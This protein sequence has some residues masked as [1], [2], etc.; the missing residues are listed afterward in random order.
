MG[1]IWLP[2]EK[3]DLLLSVE[4]YECCFCEKFISEKAMD[5][6]WGLF[7]LYYI[8]SCDGIAWE[9]ANLSKEWHFCVWLC[10]LRK[11]LTDHIATTSEVILECE[12]VLYVFNGL[13]H[14]YLT[15][16]TTFNMTQVKPF[17]G[18]LHNQLKNFERMLLAYEGVNQDLL[19]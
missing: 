6:T 13:G 9:D 15:F 14:R 4:W 11:T 8:T 1:A 18:M 3:L 19:F 12:M 5:S 10:A 16:V 7:Q 2:S 17:V